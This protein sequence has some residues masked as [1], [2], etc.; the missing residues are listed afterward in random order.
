V[1][2]RSPRLKHADA[3][4]SKVKDENIVMYHAASTLNGAQNEES[5]G[6]EGNQVYNDNKHK[7]MLVMRL[8]DSISRALGQLPDTLMMPS[9]FIV[10]ETVD[11]IAS[12]IDALEEKMK[13]EWLLNHSVIDS[14]NRA[15]CSF[16]FCRKL[17]K[18][19]T[20]LRK[21]LL[22]KHKEF[23]FAELAKCHDPYMMKWWDEEVIRPVPLMLI[24]CGSKFGYVPALVIGAS[25][26][27]VHD[28]EPE[29]WKKEQERLLK[30]KEKMALIEQKCACVENIDVTTQKQFVNHGN[31]N[32]GIRQGNNFIDVDD[33]KDEKVELSFCEVEVMQ[34]LKKKKKKKKLL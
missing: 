19:E 27:Y 32:Q 18:D 11:A 2:F 24:D 13:K 4:L 16:H 5:Q 21:H 31:N 33:M 23:L 17:F 8:D 25:E 15:R 22:K 6:K 30:E 3:I 10:N 9:P 20:F 7:D 14:D 29:M 28:P 1:L 34:P 26:P 12:E